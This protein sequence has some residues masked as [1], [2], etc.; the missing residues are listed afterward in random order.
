MRLL[1]LRHGETEWTLSGRYTGF[2]DLALTAVGRT[3]AGAQRSTLTRLLVGDTP[4]VMVS[5]RRR[6][7][8]T[9][10]LALPGY[11]RTI[12]PLLRECDY[13]DYE[14][15]TS[16]EIE[17]RA[18]GWDIWNDGCPGGETTDA[19]A[20]RADQFVAKIRATPGPVVAV[21]HGHMSRILAAR[22]VGLPA[23]C[24][25]ALGSDTGSLS[26]L[27]DHRGRPELTLWNLVPGDP[28]T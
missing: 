22:A 9:A 14:G 16:D 12:E 5:P 10:D 8:E 13:G 17:A 25:G 26:M 18:P 27:E 6:T 4:L 20:A 11:D 3:E 1:I 28:K 24:G 21:T 19:V 23:R 15:L 2:T 7:I